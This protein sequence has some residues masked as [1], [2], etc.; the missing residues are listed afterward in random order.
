MVLLKGNESKD[1]KTSSEKSGARVFISKGQS[2]RGGS[3]RS[4]NG[5]KLLDAV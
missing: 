4:C 3:G 1:L 2:S 5:E